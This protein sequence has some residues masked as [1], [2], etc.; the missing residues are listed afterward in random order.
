MLSPGAQRLPARIAAIGQIGFAG[1]SD[2]VFDRFAR[3]AHR[4]LDVPIAVVCLLDDDT[5][6]LPGQI[7]LPQE[8]TRNGAAPEQSICRRVIETGPIAVADIGEDSQNS[9]APDLRARGVVAFA[10]IPLTDQ[11]GQV[12]GSLCAIDRRRHDWSDD[13]LQSLQDVAAA[14]S[15]ELRLR[16][17]VAELTTAQV[18]SEASRVVAE[19]AESHAVESQRDADRARQQTERALSRLELLT[20]A[21]E[22]LS[23]TLDADDAIAKLARLAV[24]DLGDW[25]LVIRREDD[26]SFHIVGRA[27]HDPV[28]QPDVERFA[29]LHTPMEGGSTAEVIRTGRP[30][31][32]PEL[33]DG[34]LEDALPDPAARE[35]LRVLAPH[36]AAILPLKA[37]GHTL[38]ALALFTGPERGPHEPDE[39]TTAVEL[40]RHAA[41]V[42][43]NAMLY[44][45]QRRVA[46][47]LQRSMLSEPPDSDRLAVVARYRAATVDAQIGGDWYDAF[48]LPDGSTVLVVGDVVG[49]DLAA[50]AAMGQIRSLVRGIAYDR[51]ESPAEVLR[52]VDH[53]LVGLGMETLATVIIARIEGWV[54]ESG[55]LLVRWSS[56]GHPAPIFVGEGGPGAAPGEPD[57]LLG[58]RP[59][60]VRRNHRL[61]LPPGGT[62][63]LFT[64]GLVERRDTALDDG[65]TELARQLEALQTLPLDALCESLLSRLLPRHHDD[66]AALVVVRNLG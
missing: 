31:I 33:D 13:E 1:Q 8:S 30:T 18:A 55:G 53:T 60:V 29:E 7:G 10:G 24:P 39:I 59:D 50:A 65:A 19:S 35:A 45:R 12:L 56:A 58:L 54:D 9:A 43:D 21:S 57:L 64:D 2:P 17:T 25:C 27:H 44:G 38:G 34:V 63:A 11:T 14:V 47:T 16:M 37:R 28:W 62:L 6:F 40:A 15:G 26:G 36:G 61:I 4:L 41:L 52:R 48:V 51:S 23:A 5:H 42:L 3:L 66:D 22:V 20:Q 49:H 32:Y 46:E